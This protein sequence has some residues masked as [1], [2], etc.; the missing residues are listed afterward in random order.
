MWILMNQNG[1]NAERLCLSFLISPTNESINWRD[2]S[3]LDDRSLIGNH[4]KTVWSDVLLILIFPST[5]VVRRCSIDWKRTARFNLTP[6]IGG[7]G[8]TVSSRTPSSRHHLSCGLSITTWPQ[9]FP[10]QI[11][12]QELLLGA[13][14][15]SPVINR[16]SSID[17][18]IQRQSWPLLNKRVSPNELLQQW[19]WKLEW[20]T[21]TQASHYWGDDALGEYQIEPLVSDFF[22]SQNAFVAKLDYRAPIFLL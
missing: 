5:I 21:S 18:V 16:Q 9:F 3:S 13:A 4:I 22:T 11:T 2:A 20:S 12:K 6:L 7:E 8:N 17:A 10:R 19:S 14:F 15:P 1:M